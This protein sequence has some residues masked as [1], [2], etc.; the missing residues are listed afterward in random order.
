MKQ[1]RNIRK[2]ALVGAI[3]GIAVFAMG[4]GQTAPTG[5][6]V[7]QLQQGQTLEQQGGN[8]VGWEQVPR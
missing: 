5:V 8:T 3:V 6:D 1:R 2:L 4:C 7:Q